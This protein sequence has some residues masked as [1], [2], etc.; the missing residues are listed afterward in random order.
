MTTRD[1]PHMSLELIRFLTRALSM[2]RRSQ[3]MKFEGLKSFLKTTCLSTAKG[4][5]VRGATLQLPG[6][7]PKVKICKDR[8]QIP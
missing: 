7:G 1:K 4:S 2:P 5:P 8:V 3:K 6:K